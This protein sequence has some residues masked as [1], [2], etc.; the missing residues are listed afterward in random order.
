MLWGFYAEKKR[1]PMP[2]FSI[3]MPCYNAETYLAE[4]VG[5]ALGQSEPDFELIVVDDGSTD[6]SLEV[7]AQFHDPRIQILQQ[8]N[9]GA[10][11]ARN[12]GI[13]KAQGEWIA[14]LDADDLWLP[15]KLQTAR[16][17]IALG[18]SRLG[19]WHHNYRE[20]GAFG[21]R[22]ANPLKLAQGLRLEGEVYADLIIH[23]FIA[24]LTVVA[25]KAALEQAEGFDQGLR[26]PEDWDLWI[27][28]SQAWEVGYCPKPLAK[29][30][31]LVTGLSKNY[32]L[33]EKEIYKVLQRHLL[34]SGNKKAIAQGLWIH[35]R[36]MAHGFAR[37]KERA[38][39]LSHWLKAL[40]AR[41][42]AA[43]NW[44]SLLW[45]LLKLL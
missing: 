40:R 12:Q 32:K 3:I 44:S 4:A 30:R 13:Q 33:Y 7:L 10:A 16:A 8:K 34:S 23:N 20:F 27:K 26:G 24:T 45:I 9:Q 25:R 14:F 36:H 2:L 39:S 6:R 28:I 29:Y 35:H 41:P 11:A 31:Q 21:E 19:L 42:R 5:S 15:D 38:L 37:Q 22:A 1:E 17:A 43:S 18:G